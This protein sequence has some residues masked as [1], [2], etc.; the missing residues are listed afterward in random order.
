VVR[1]FNVLLK[2]ARKVNAR[3]LLRMKT[4][5]LTKIAKLEAIAVLL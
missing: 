2:N 1:T 5:T 3:D 4:A